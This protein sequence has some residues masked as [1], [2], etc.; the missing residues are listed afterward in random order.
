MACSARRAAPALPAWLGPALLDAT[1][2]AKA[3]NEKYARQLKSSAGLAVFLAQREDHDHWVRVGRASQR[4]ALQATALGLRHAFVNQPVEVA[5]LRPALA[6]LV[7]MPGRRPDLV[8]R[9]GRGP[10]LPFS[11]RRPARI[12]AALDGV[13]TR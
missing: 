5:S 8:M 11:A 7:A 6:D 10:T 2:T 12:E 3:E 13:T 1:F 9:F 4:F